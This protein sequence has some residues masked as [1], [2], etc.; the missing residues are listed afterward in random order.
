MWRYVVSACLPVYQP[1]SCRLYFTSELLAP[2]V[3]SY[4][5][6]YPYISKML[7]AMLGASVNILGRAYPLLLLV[8]FAKPFLYAVL[9]TTSPKG[10]RQCDV[11][12]V[13]Q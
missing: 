9:P 3:D 1:K 8:L 13:C 11:W 2:F 12:N 4:N 5:E 6:T 7:P 10:C